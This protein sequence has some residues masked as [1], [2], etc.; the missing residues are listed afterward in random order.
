MF[1][2][3]SRLSSFINKRGVEAKKVVQRPEIS[4]MNLELKPEQ[5]IEKHEAD[6]HVTFV[7]L[8]GSGK[9][10]I[11]D[12]EY[13]VEPSNVVLCEPQ[14]PMELRGGKEGMSFLNIKTPNPA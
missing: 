5:R 8:K 11:G 6:V 13:E 14:V 9:I 7:V 3:L 12:K 2:D 10:V 4:M 1:I